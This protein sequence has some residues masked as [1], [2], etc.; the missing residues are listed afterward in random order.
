[1]KPT[2]PYVE[3]HITY[4]AITG[5]LQTVTAEM[6]QGLVLGFGVDSYLLGLDG[7]LR[8]LQRRRG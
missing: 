2:L 8:I 3:V 4:R 1:V 5:G 7:L 6:S